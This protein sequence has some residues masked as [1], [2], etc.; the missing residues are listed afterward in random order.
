MTHG[1][2]PHKNMLYNIHF[3][4]INKTPF[5]QGYFAQQIKTKLIW[6]T[7]NINV[8]NIKAT[9]TI[10]KFSQNF[11]DFLS[12]IQTL[13]HS[14]PKFQPTCPNSNLLKKNLPEIFKNLYQILFY[15]HTKI[16]LVESN[17]SSDIA[18]KLWHPQFAKYFQYP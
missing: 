18:L 15:N 12:F 6:S 1:K 13:T 7:K 3:L 8:N 14:W 5:I 2:T 10:T 9:N 17:F 11:Y 4:N 16:K